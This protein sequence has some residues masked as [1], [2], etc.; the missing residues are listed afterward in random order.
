[1]SEGA[2]PR[3]GVVARK[4]ARQ[5]AGPPVVQPARMA[6]SVL[7]VASDWVALPFGGSASTAPTPPVAGFARPAAVAAAFGRP[8]DG[9][10]TRPASRKRASAYADATV[11]SSFRVSRRGAPGLGSATVI[12]RSPAGAGV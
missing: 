10:D 5:V 7:T 2:R 11:V 12:R 3:G 6:A 1:M 8:G 9:P 4:S